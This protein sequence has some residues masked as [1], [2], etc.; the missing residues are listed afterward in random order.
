MKERQSTIGWPFYLAAL[1]DSTELVEAST[2]LP[3]DI[4]NQRGAPH[5][6]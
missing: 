1:R 6:R 4:E 3:P 5:R 2:A